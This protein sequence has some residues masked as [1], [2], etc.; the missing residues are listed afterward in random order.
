MKTLTVN[1]NDAYEFIFSKELS[2]YL[3]THGILAQAK[4][5]A[6]LNAL[7]FGGTTFA[8]KNASTSLWSAFSWS[9]TF[10]GYGFWANH[11]NRFLMEQRVMSQS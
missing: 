8:S 1:E 2:Q 9:D 11:H 10:E 7:R 3:K 6:R 4:E 5:Y